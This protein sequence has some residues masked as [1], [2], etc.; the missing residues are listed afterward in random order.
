M[1]KRLAELNK[2]VDK[3]KYYHLV[4]AVQLLKQTAK[5][6]FDETVEI[7]IRLGIDPKQSDQNVRGTIVLPSGLG[8]SKKVLVI[9]KGEKLKEAETSGAEYFGGDELIEK[10]SKGWMDFDVIVATPD[11]MRD[12]SKLGKILGPRG[13]MPNPK[14]GT[15]TFEIAKAVK[16]IKTGKIEFKVDSTGII[17]CGIGKASFPAEK[18]AENAQALI[19]AVLKSKAPTVKGQYL[20][21]ITISTTMGPGIKLDINQKFD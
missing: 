2:L 17:H 4:E 13:L 20:K 21:S 19:E 9:A 18:I 3:T 14:T 11:I 12:L 5:A 10:I 16:E 7:A 6:K 15:V 8:K 1:S